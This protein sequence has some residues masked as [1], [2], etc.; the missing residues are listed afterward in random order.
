MAADEAEEDELDKAEKQIEEKKAKEASAEQ[1]AQEAGMAVAL[2]LA[3][4]GLFEGTNP[5]QDWVGH[6]KIC[7]ERKAE[8]PDDRQEPQQ[9]QQQQLDQ[10]PWC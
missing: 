2:G 9:K 6:P 7:G 5:S 10:S 4:P 3:T 8:E 1:Q